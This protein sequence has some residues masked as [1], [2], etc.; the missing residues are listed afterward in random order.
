MAELMQ[1]AVPEWSIKQL[2]IIQEQRCENK[3]TPQSSER[4]NTG[5][6]FT[7]RPSEC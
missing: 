4:S 3:Q 1:T 2:N 7:M 5:V 6:A